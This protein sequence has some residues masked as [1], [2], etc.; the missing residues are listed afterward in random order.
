M[1]D[2][3][4][5]KINT[6]GIT[7]TEGYIKDEHFELIIEA[8]LGIPENELY[9]IDGRGKEKFIFKVKSEARY[10]SNCENF[11]GKE[12]EIEPGFKF[13]IDNIS[14]NKT[15]VC[16]TRVPFEVNNDMLQ[17]FF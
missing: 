3:D 10:E 16:I 6:I 14:A 13:R 7:F 12:I 8:K 17:D 2:P 4:L 11:L 15:R 5:P 9:G 1:S